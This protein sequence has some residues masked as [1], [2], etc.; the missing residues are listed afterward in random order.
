[1]AGRKAANKTKR[2]G[3]AAGGAKRGGA[4]AGGARARYAGN[5][6]AARGVQQQA[7]APL[8][9]ATRDSLKIIISNLP[10]DVDEAAVRVSRFANPLPHVN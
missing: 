6:P 5:V 1:M 8:S 10:T 2:G 4:A 7:V 9:Q 3:A